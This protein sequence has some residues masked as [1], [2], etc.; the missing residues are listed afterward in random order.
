LAT[1]DYR[2]MEDDADVEQMLLERR[3]HVEE[4]LRGVKC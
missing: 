2:E 4:T 1:R 3:E